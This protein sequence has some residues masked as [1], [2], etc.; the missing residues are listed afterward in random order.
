VHSSYDLLVRNRYQLRVAQV[1]GGAAAKLSKIGVVRKSIARVLT[2]HNQMVKSKLREKF[3]DEKM[4]IELRQKKTRAMRRR[5][6]AEQVFIENTFSPPR[7]LRPVT[8]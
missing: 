6:T 4:P 8:E 7:C 5:L 3:G 1:T 2:V